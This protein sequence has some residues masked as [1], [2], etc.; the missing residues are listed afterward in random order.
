MD[1]LHSTKIIQIFLFKYF[2]EVRHLECASW[3]YTAAGH[4]K[5]AADAIGGTVKRMCD[6]YVTFG[7]SI[8][9]GEDIVNLLTNS[10]CRIN[11][12]LVMEDN[13]KN[14]ETLVPKKL[15]SIKGTVKVHQI[16]WCSSHPLTSLSFRHLSCTLCYLKVNCDHFTIV[17][18]NN[19]NNNNKK[20]TVISQ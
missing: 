19:N 18:N 20:A 4:G 9:C 7:N 16:V 3:N 10:N 15:E 14:I 6:R 2:C 12:F 5:S 1:Q 13:I 17:S 11:I 8:L